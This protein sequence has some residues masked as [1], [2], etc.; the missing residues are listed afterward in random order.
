MLKDLAMVLNAGRGF[1]CERTDGPNPES[2][3]E[4][5]DGPRVNPQKTAAQLI[6]GSMGHYRK[7][8][9]EPQNQGMDGGVPSKEI[10]H[11]LH[12]ALPSHPCLTQVPMKCASSAL[13][14]K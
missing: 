4:G 9:S 13:L 14:A 8:S 2:I 12:T 11:D 5:M 7:I 1:P 10:L 6:S 3:T